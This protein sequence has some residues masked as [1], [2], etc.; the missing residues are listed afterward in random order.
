M[1]TRRLAEAVEYSQ[2]VL[3]RNVGQC[4]RLQADG[5]GPRPSPLKGAS[6]Q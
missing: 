1:T 2:P 3:Y 5:V 6:V 4:S